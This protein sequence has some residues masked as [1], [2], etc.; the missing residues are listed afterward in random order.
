M[1]TNWP[2]LGEPSSSQLNRLVAA[3]A[4]QNLCAAAREANEGTDMNTFDLLKPSPG[5]R[6]LVTGGAAG[7]ARR[8]PRRLTRL[9]RAYRSATSTPLAVEAI[10]K[11]TPGIPAAPKT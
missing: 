9:A 10:R 7:I 2:R 1:R 8:S 6:V 4:A 3:L 5:M 11:D